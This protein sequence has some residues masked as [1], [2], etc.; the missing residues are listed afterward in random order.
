MSDVH[1]W[2][3]IGHDAVKNLLGKQLASGQVG[4]AYL[5]LGPE[6]VGK[7]T[8]AEEFAGKLSARSATVVRHTF[9]DTGMTEL[10]EL[11]SLLALRPPAGTRQVAILDAVEHIS[12]AAANALLKTLEEPSSST[13]LIL[14]SS[15]RTLPATVLSRC[16]TFSFGVLTQGELQDITA[17]RSLRLSE[18]LLKAA[19]GRA[20]RLLVSEDVAAGYVAWQKDLQ[21]VITAP[22]SERV[23][24]AA[25]FAG[26]E[27]DVLTNRLEY[28]LEDLRLRASTDSRL[29][30]RLKVVWEGWQRLRQNGNKKLVM[31]YV[32]LNI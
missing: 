29:V 20:S 21:S 28:W 3:T 14:V 12:P 7:R 1:H 2:S 9:A 13:V 32:C 8:L 18:A 4:H 30:Q 17:L 16:Q 25:N 10:R 6:G 5:F 15:Q 23:S 19:S 24:L 11:L 27:T 22:V 31:E 26:E